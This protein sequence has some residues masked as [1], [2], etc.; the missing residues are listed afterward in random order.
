M[1][2]AISVV[3][4]DEDNVAQLARAFFSAATKESADDE[5]ILPQVRERVFEI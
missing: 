1:S 4:A 3:V 5:D 2:T